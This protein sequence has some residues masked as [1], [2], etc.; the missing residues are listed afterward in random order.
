M[1]NEWQYTN[2]F[3]EEG[4]IHHLSGGSVNDCPYNYL[5]EDI[6]QDDPREVQQ[7]LYR[8]QEWYTGFRSA[9]MDN[10]QKTA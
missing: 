7:E 8:Q 9:F 2:Q 5:S 4:K 6:N 3:F 1:A 10:L